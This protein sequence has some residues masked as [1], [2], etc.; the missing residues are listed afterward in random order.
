MTCDEINDIK[1]CPKP[2]CTVFR[3]YSYTN[4][5]V[6]VGFGAESQL[7]FVSVHYLLGSRSHKM[8]PSTIHIM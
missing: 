5:Y 3:G 4:N 6:H 8:L 2:T 1:Q 7:S